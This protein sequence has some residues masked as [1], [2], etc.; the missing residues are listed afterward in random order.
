MASILIS[1]DRIFILYADHEQNP[2]TST[3]RLL[4]RRAQIRLPASPRAW[5]AYGARRMAV[6]AKPRSKC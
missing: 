5:R 2:S 4:A 3:V 1:M 6:P